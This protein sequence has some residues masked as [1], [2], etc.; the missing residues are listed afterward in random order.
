MPFGMQG[1][2]WDGGMPMGCPLGCR[3][4]H[5]MPMG[6]WDPFCPFLWGRKWLGRSCQ[7]SE[8]NPELQRWEL[9]PQPSPAQ[10]RWAQGFPQGCLMV[11][12][13]SFLHFCSMSPSWPFPGSLSQSVSLGGPRSILT[14]FG[15]R[16]LPSSPAGTRESRHSKPLG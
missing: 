5:G 15:M 9:S 11:E 16:A 8:M 6:W 13:P 12:F 1:C 2:P 10:P 7:A 3:D 4:A 14:C